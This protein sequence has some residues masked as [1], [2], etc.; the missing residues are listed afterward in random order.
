[1]GPSSESLNDSVS[2]LT[3]SLGGLGSLL[4][5]GTSGT[6]HG[7]QIKARIMRARASAMP[8]RIPWSMGKS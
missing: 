3:T 6:L 1:M 2:I 4:G 5:M 8:M 7:V